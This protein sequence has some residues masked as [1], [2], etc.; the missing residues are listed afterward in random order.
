MEYGR[1]I[2]EECEWEEQEKMQRDEV[3]ESRDREVEEQRRVTV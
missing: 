1:G 2:E 3:Q